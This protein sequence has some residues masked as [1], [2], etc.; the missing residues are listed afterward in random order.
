MSSLDQPLPSSLLPAQSNPDP[1]V[2]R[3]RLSDL[4][5]IFDLIESMTGDGT[6]LRRSRRELEREIDTFVVAETG[7]G[8]FLGCAALHRYG[9]HLAEVRSIAVKPEARGCGAGGLLLQQLLHD[10]ESTGA[11]CACLFT[12]IP[13]F[14][15]HYGFH[16]VSLS[17]IPDKFAKDCIRCPRR[18]HCDEIAMALGELPSSAPSTLA[19]AQSAQQLVQL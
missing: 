15:A 18:E 8:E 3:A 10:I 12:R 4:G 14:F 7:T 9:P 19:A 6:L 5:N 11:G 2:R 16:D 17:S 1:R 13:S